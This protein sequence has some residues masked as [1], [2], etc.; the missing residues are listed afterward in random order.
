MKALVLTFKPEKQSFYFIIFFSNKKK[1]VDSSGKGTTILRLSWNFL[2]PKG[3]M[4][5]TVGFQM[6]FP[7]LNEKEVTYF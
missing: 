5:F 1:I 7:I 2:N 4:N 3:M 6:M